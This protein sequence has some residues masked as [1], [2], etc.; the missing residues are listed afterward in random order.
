[1]KDPLP[2]LIIAGVNKGGTTSVFSYLTRHPEICGSSVKETCYFLPIRY[3]KVLPPLEDYRSQFSRCA[4]TRYRLEATPGYYYGG[5]ELAE[6]IAETLG[7][8][9]VLLLF[10]E[11]VDRLRSFFSFQKTMVELDPDLTLGAYVDRCLA[12]PKSEVAKREND[13]FTGVEG[14]F[15]DRDFPAWSQTFGDALKV[16]FFEDLKLDRRALLFDLCRW[17]E[18]DPS[19]FETMAL[20][21][22]NRTVGYRSRALQQ[23]ALAANTRGEK[24]WRRMPALKR[25]LRGG[26]RALNGR[27]AEVKK[28]EDEKLLQRLQAMYLP[29]NHRFADQLRTHGIRGLPAWLQR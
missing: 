20:N 25:L 4:T 27:D 29:H 9:R 10:R 3:G 26:Y 13:P 7:D 12:M 16:A 19:P 14:G 5:A 22:E 17:L 15:Y 1:M 8:V 11:P 18:L 28:D 21:I 23:L 24:M 2:N 6:R